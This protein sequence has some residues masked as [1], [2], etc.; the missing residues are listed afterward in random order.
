[1]PSTQAKRWSRRRGQRL[2]DVQVSIAAEVA[3]AYITLRGAQV[4]LAIA[5]DNLETQQETLQITEWRQQAGLATS[6]DVEQ[7]RTSTEQTRA[8]LPALRTSAEQAR[9]ALAV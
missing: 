4:H 5:E 9:H 7:A 8:L 2:G 1:M 3:L 6:L